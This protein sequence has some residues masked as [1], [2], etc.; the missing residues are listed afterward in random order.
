MEELTDPIRKIPISTRPFIYDG[1]VWQIM[2]FRDGIFNKIMDKLMAQFMEAQSQYS[3][4]FAVRLDFRLKE[5][6]SGNTIIT[7]FFKALMPQLQKRY[8]CTIR[9]SYVRELSK[10]S[11]LPHYHAVFLFSGHV[12]NYP[13][14]IIHIIKLEIANA[15]PLLGLVI[16]ENCFYLTYR[17]RLDSQQALIYRLSYLA[18]RDTKENSKIY[19]NH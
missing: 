6:V 18:K 12:V 9:Y 5:K 13:S 16:P 10:S 4:V 17:N 7:R 3:K 19:Q 11:A 14:E 1:V 2:D 15:H 8:Q